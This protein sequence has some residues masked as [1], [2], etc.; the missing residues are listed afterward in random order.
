MKE[1]ISR[2]KV[3]HVA[4]LARLELSEQE[5]LRMTEQMNRILGYMDQ[6]NELN[7]EKIPPTTHA[8]QLQNVFRED[9]VQ[10][11]L[12]REQALANAPQ[13]DGVNF[14]VPRVI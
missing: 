1:K 5:E 14:I 4:D 2:E 11:S 7:T 3:R 8:I 6:L 10:D 13:T 9:E 12:P